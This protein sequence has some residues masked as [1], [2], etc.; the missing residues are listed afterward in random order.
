M[1]LVSPS[2]SPP[3]MASSFVGRASSP[4]VGSEGRSAAA[5]AAFGLGLT[6]PGAVFEEVLL[7]GL[8]CASN[9]DSGTWPKSIAGASISG[10]EVLIC[11]EPF[12][13][14]A[15]SPLAESPKIGSWSSARLPY[16]EPVLELMLTLSASEGAC[17]NCEGPS[18]KPLPLPYIASRPQYLLVTYSSVPMILGSTKILL[19]SPSS[20]SLS[21]SASAKL[22]QAILKLSWIFSNKPS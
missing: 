9:A 1:G 20:L 4:Y 2:P 12:I 13:E 8:L 22:E 14:K 19:P 17:M 5:G 10:M 18:S 16:W 6:S 3:K 11:D 15:A 7:L 21:S